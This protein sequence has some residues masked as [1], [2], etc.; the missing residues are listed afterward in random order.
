MGAE[1]NTS[2][3]IVPWL[4]WVEAIGRAFRVVD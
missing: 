1:A 4:E 3:D 2:Y